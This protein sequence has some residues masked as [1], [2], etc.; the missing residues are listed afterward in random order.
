MIEIE[1]VKYQPKPLLTTEQ[2]AQATGLSQWELRAGW[3]SGKYPAL[4]IGSGGKRTRLRWRLDLLEAAIV[5]AMQE[6]EHEDEQQI[7]R[8]WD[9][10]RRG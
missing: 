7:M 5:K 6:Q 2:A 9:A 1:R 4:A 8:E 10:R 3:K